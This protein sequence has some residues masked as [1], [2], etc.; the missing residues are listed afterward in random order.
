MQRIPLLISLLSLVLLATTAWPAAPAIALPPSA[1][2]ETGSGSLERLVIAARDGEAHVYLHGAHVTHF[3]PRHSGPVLW[4]SKN[5]SFVGG[6]PGKPIRGGVPVVFPWFADNLPK[7]G[8]PGHGL[9]RLFPWTLTSCT[10]LPDHRVC[11]VLELRSDGRTRPLFPHEFHLKLTITVGSELEMELTAANTG[12][13]PFTCEEALH[14]YFAVGDARQVSV[15]G[16]EGAPYIDKVDSYRRKTGEAGALRITAETDRIYAANRAA[17][18]IADP[19]LKRTITVEKTGSQSTVV[20][21]PWIRKGEALLDL[22]GQQWPWMLCVETA[23]VGTDAVTLAPGAS[24]TL[25]AR[26]HIRAL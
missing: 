19:V 14:T 9:A 15:S 13:S 24:H 26:I 4:V 22:A 7:K 6:S 5:S 2:L 18:S 23:N 20:W 17:V 25:T 11:A 1:R 10:E 21:N 16:L 12:S 8:D 3:K